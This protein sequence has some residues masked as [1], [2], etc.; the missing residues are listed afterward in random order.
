[1]SKVEAQEGREI[2]TTPEQDSVIEA[3]A[4]PVENDRP[5]SAIE[6]GIAPEGR[7][8]HQWFKSTYFYGG[9]ILIAVTITAMGLHRIFVGNR[10]PKIVVAG[11]TEQITSLKAE[12]RRLQNTNSEQLGE[13]SSLTQ[14][15]QFEAIP[16]EGQQNPN[17]K[18]NLNAQQ[19]GTATNLAARPG[20]TTT[21]PQTPPKGQVRVPAR[22]T[23]TPRNTVSLN[24]PRY[25]APAPVRA[26]RPTVAPAKPRTAL[27]AEPNPTL[28]NCVEFLQ[29]GINV[30]A[31]AKHRIS[32]KAQ[33]PTK[34]ITLG[35]TTP[36]STVTKPIKPVKLTPYKRPVKTAYA[37]PSAPKAKL[38]HQV[39]FMA[40]EIQTMDQ[41]DQEF[42]GNQSPASSNAPA[43]S[44]MSAKVVRH[45]E[46][47]S[48]DEAQRVIIPLTITSGP[49]KGQSA[50]A[51]I[52]SLNGTQFTAELTKLNNQPVGP[53]QYMIE[54]KNTTYLLAQYK[55]QGGSS[56][57]KQVLGAALAV[58][59]EIAS[60]QLGNVRG[61]SHI[62]NLVPRGGQQGPTGEY[63]KFS[64]NVDIVAKS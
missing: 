54:Q 44:K 47:R 37:R 58:G 32:I 22:R 9:V 51:K 39:N 50:E 19:P 56:F 30:P 18:G 53:G 25:T 17:A 14:G 55:T 64:G 57:G 27:K 13:N 5:I 62:S 33:A 63:W 12:I 60:D 26:Y 41:Y 34:P 23:V 48:Q 59:G 28:E 4:Q 6:T 42:S 52:T 49:H 24:R 29:G 45:V 3:L 35:Q 10:S 46:W 38:S 1:M 7:K 15:A 61:G 11:E 21:A 31:C 16:L 2:F 20:T 36:T 43:V 8:T 40:G